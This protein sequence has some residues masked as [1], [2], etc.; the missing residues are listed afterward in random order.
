MNIT[1]MVESEDDMVGGNNLAS[2]KEGAG[3]NFFSWN[4]EHNY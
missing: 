1:L 3:V 4:I 2:L